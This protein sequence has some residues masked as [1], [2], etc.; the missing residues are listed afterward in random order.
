MRIIDYI[1]ES[2]EIQDAT[3]PDDFI[4]MSLAYQHATTMWIGKMNGIRYRYIFMSDL[5]PLICDIRGGVR[6]VEFRDTP[7]HFANGNVVSGGRD[8]IKRQVNMLIENAS[9]FTPTEFY[10]AF[11]QIHPWD[12][13]NGRVGSLLFNVLNNTI[14]D[15]IHPP[16]NPDWDL[17]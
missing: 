9:A 6:W 14:C 1:R 15:P 11:E 8:M 13:G 17:R 7:V 5:A 2:C 3:T 10:W 4:G 12:D 16:H